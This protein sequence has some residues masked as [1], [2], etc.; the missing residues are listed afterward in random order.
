MSNMLFVFDDIW[1]QE[2]LKY[3][4]FAKKSIVTSRFNNIKNINTYYCISAPVRNYFH[5]I[6]SYC[7][8]VNGFKYH[9]KHSYLYK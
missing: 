1:N 8:I 4:T 3:L 5:V 2:H 6:I 7:N 9:F